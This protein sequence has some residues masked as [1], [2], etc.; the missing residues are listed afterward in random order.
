MQ[1]ILEMQNVSFQFLEHKLL[2][3]INLSFFEG[4]ITA[5]VGNSGSGKSTLGKLLIGL[6]SPQKGKII[7]QGNRIESC[8]MI[9]QHPSSSLN[10]KLTIYSILQE[11][12]KIKGISS[13]L[14]KKPILRMIKNVGLKKEHLLCFPKELSG[15]MQQR[16][17]IARALLLEPKFLI[18]DEI[19]SSLDFLVQKEII[20]LLKKIQQ[21]KKL[22][23]LVITHDLRL[24]Y[25][26][27]DHVF[28]LKEGR[29]I[30]ESLHVRF[31]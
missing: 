11:P 2:D 12:L 5:L 17:A 20:D 31:L 6:L 24:A 30:K 16:V 4:E 10:P 27:A 14:Q 26:L 28:F 23:L 19:T 29:V 13:S 25:S 1:P 21:E 7:Y 3:Q 9:F 22:T 18:C 15:G 8:Q